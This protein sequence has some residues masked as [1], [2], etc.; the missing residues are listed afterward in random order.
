MLRR[1]TYPVSWGDTGRG[2]AQPSRV[3]PGMWSWVELDVAGLG[4]PSAPLKLPLTPIC[5]A[6][7][8]T[9]QEGAAAHA[10]YEAKAGLGA[11]QGKQLPSG[12]LVTGVSETAIPVSGCS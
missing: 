1:G 5:S 6:F 4:S 12:I 2:Q 9:G 3:H 10:R 8:L 7:S 11:L